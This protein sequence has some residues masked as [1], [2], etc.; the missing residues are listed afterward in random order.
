MNCLKLV[1]VVE[2]IEKGGKKTQLFSSNFPNMAF[3]M[4]HP[5]SQQKKSSLKKSAACGM[6]TW[7][8]AVCLGFQWLLKITL[9]R[10]II[11][12]KQP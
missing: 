8:D 2:I 3:I 7:A 5:A 12:M 11:E 6:G 9:H 4:G 1:S 10:F